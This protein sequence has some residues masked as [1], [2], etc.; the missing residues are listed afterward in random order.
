[1]PAPNQTKTEI[2]YSAWQ[3]FRS[4]GYH[5]TTYASIAKDCSIGRSLVQ[6]HFP[7]KEEL[8]ISLVSWALE[9]SGQCLGT[10][11]ENAV[12]DHVAFFK[13]GV[14]TF[15]FLLDRGFSRFLLEILESRAIT[16]ALL[17]MNVEWSLARTGP[18]FAADREKLVRAVVT[19][20]GGFYDYLYH[21]LSVGK[22][23]DVAD[24][25]ATSVYASATALAEHHHYSPADFRMDEELA[26]EIYTAVDAISDRF[27]SF[28]SKT[29]CK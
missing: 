10:T 25:L 14:C 21:C 1:M 19:N 7:R 29:K 8:A 6:Y 15:T 18:G 16:E 26:S 9:Q 3:Q 27:E 23:F 13:I 2:A 5:T 17:A 28:V 20:M 11:V 24:C 4:L 12:D 22:A